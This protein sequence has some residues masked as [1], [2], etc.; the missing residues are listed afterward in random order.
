MA[1]DT[2]PTRVVATQGWSVACDLPDGGVVGM[3]TCGHV[4]IRRPHVAGA[5]GSKALELQPVR[6]IGGNIRGGKAAVVEEETVVVVDAAGKCCG[7][8]GSC[9]E[10]EGHRPERKRVGEVE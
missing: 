3:S 6:L 5:A 1:E 4:C 2:C 10:R 8:W 7:V 9:S